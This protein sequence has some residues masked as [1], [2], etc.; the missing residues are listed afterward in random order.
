MFRYCSC[1]LLPLYW[2]LSSGGLVGRSGQAAPVIS[3]L[4]FHPAHGERVPEPVEHEWIEIFNPGPA[5]D[6]SGWRLT[7]GVDLEFPEGTVVPAGGRLVVAAR[8]E[9]FRAAYIKFTGRLVGG[10]AGRLSNGGETVRLVD[11]EGSVIDEVTYADEGDWATRGRTAV[12]AYGRVGW[13]WFNAADGGG[14]SLEK[15]VE[16]LRGSFGRNWQPSPIDGGTPGRPNT[17]SVSEETT[18]ITDVAAAPAI[19]RPGQ[20]IVITAT[21][22]DV[23][24]GSLA[25]RWLLR[26]RVDGEE[27]FGS[28]DMIET[29]R[30]ALTAPNP[31]GQRVEV[32]ATLPGQANRA[33]IEFYLEVRGSNGRATWP[34]LA[35]VTVPGVDPPQFEPA[36]NALIQV[37]DTYHS[38]TPWSPGAQPI[39]RLVL[40]AAELAY[41]RDLQTRPSRA[42]S[43]ATMNATFIS[44][45]GAGV[46]VRWLCGVR[47]RGYSSRN[48]PPNN[49]HLSFPGDARWEE[50]GSVQFNCR[51][52][53][54][55]VLGTAAYALAG[56][57]VQEAAPVQVRLNGTN[58]AVPFSPGNEFDAA[59]TRGSYA[60]VET[61]GGDWA[62]RHY[63]DDSEG[64]LY[65]VDDHAPGNSS[66]TNDFRYPGS[67]DPDLYDDVY[68]KQTN[69]DLNDYSDLAT[70]F[71][72]L[73][74]TA[75]EEFYARIATHLNLDQWLTYFAIDALMGNMEGGFVNGRT[76]DFSMYRGTL[77]PRFV[78]IPHDMDTTFNYGAGGAGNPVTRGLFSYVTSGGGVA[79]LQR[80]FSDPDILR[81]Y[82]AKVL[83]LLDTVFTRP[84]FDPLIDQL[85]GGWVNPA[86]VLVARTYIDDRRSNVL[87]QIPRTYS[88]NSNL[89]TEVDGFAVTTTGTAVF[90]GTFDVSRTGSIRLNG[91]PATLYYRAGGENPAGSWRF[92]STNA[93]GFLGRGVTRV[94]AEFFD[95]AGGTGTLLHRAHLDVLNTAGGAMTPV[96]SSGVPMAS[97]IHV[98]AP[99]TYM[100]GHPILVKVERRDALGGIDRS[101]W[102]ESVT[103]TGNNGIELTA[104][105]GGPATV[106]LLNGRGSL[107][108]IVGGGTAQVRTLIEPGGTRQSPNASAALWKYLDSGGAPTATWRTSRSF[109]DSAWKPVD[110][111]GAPGHFGA[112]DDD[113]RTAVAN[114]P[115]SAS[116][117]DPRFTWYFRHR[118]EVV[119]PEALARASLRVLYD[120][121]V[122]VYVN[123]AEIVRSNLPADAAHTTPAIDIRSGTA[124]NSFETFDLPVASLVAGE[125]LIAVELHNARTGS[126]T[127]SLDLGFDLELRATERVVDP[128]DFTLTATAG[129]V[130]ASQAVVSLGATPTV[131]EVS[132]VL[133]GDTSWS[134]VVRVT[135]DV[136]VPPGRT[137]TVQPGTHVLL[138]G[139]TAAGDTNGSDLVVQGALR[140]DGTAAAPISLTAASPD[141]RWGEIVLAGGGVST[142]SH[143]LISRGGHSPGRGHTGRGPMLRLAEASATLDDCVLSDAPGKAIFTEGIG[144]LVVRRSHLARCVTGPELGNGMSLL[145]EDSHFTHFLPEY[146]ESDAPGPDD[147]DCLYVHNASGRPVVVRRSVLGRCGDDVIDGLGGPVTIEDCLIRD[148]WDKGVSLLNNDLTMTRT[149]VIGCDKAV[150]AKSSTATTRS[151]TTTQCTLVS[152]NHDT[153]R[154]PWGYP[155]DPTNPDD[156]TPSTGMYTQNKAAQSHTGATIAMQARNCVIVA[157]EPIRVDTPY[158]LGGTAVAYS[159]TRNPAQPL[160]APWPGPGNLSADPE[161]VAAAGASRDFRLRPASPAVNAGDPASPA[162]PDGS[163][164]DMGALPLGGRSIEPPAEIVWK[165]AQSPLHVQD[166]IVIP[167][168]KSLTI[169]PGVC[170]IFDQNRRLTVHGVLRAL[171]TPHARI[172]FS[173]VPGAVAVGDADPIVPGIQIGPPKWGGVRIVDSMAE[174]NRVGHATFIN[175]QG[176]ASTGSEN[177]GSVGIIRSWALCEHLDFGGTKLRWLYGRNSKLTVQQCRFP[178]RF[179][180]DEDPRDF[181]LENAAEH[182]K[183]EFP[184]SDPEVQDNPI[185]IDGFP[186]GGWLRIYDNDFFGTKGLNDALAAESGRWGGGTFVLDCQFNRFHGPVGDEHIELSGDAYIAS[187]FFQRAT[188]DEWTTDTGH[189]AAVFS[190]SRGNGTTIMM[191]RNVITGV[192]H[193]LNL[194][195]GAAAFFEHNTAVRL[196]PDYDH[197][198]GPLPGTV[199]PIATSVVNLFVPE[200]GPAPIPGHGAYFGFN[201]A[202]DIPRF[203]G[204]ADRSATGLGAVTSQLQ[205]EYN[206]LDRLADPSIGPNHP[207]GFFDPRWG[208]N[209]Q[210]APGFIDEA[211][212]DFRLAVGSDARGTAPGGLDFGATVAEWAYV[213]GGPPALTAQTSASFAIGGPGLVAFRWSLDGGAWSA[214]VP[215]GSGGLYPRNGTSVRQGVLTLEALPAGNHAL[216]VLGQD[217]A[218]NWQPESAPTTRDWMVDP[219]LRLVLI[220]EIV[221]DGGDEPDWIELHNAGA[222]TVDLSGWALGESTDTPAYSFPS[223]TKL[224]AGAYL[225]I[226]SPLSGIASDNDGDAVLLWEGALLRDRVAFGAQ[227]AGF[228]L[229]R[230]GADMTWGLG[231]PTPG[232]ANQPALLGSP[233]ALRLSEWLAAHDVGYSDD[234]IELHNPGPLPVAMHGLILTDNR[235]GRPR[236]HIVAPLSFIAPTSHVAFWADGE[237]DGA[238]NHISFR[239]NALQ[240]RL[241]LLDANGTVIDEKILYGQTNDFSQSTDPTGRVVFHE[242]PTRGF[243]M[244]DS[245]PLYRN[246]VVVLRQLRLTEL[247]FNARGGNDFDWLELTNVGLVA[248]DL[249]GLRFVE[250]IDFVLPALVLNPGQSVVVVANTAAFQSRYGST[251]VVAGVY[252]G[253]LDNAGETLALRLAPPFDANALRFRYEDDWYPDTDGAGRA[254]DLAA[255]DIPVSQLDQASAWMA[256]EAI[257]GTPGIAGQLPPGHYQAWKAFYDVAEGDDD[258]D[259]MP[260]LLEFALGLNPRVCAAMPGSPALP[261][262][263]LN[264]NGR[265]ELRVR[266]PAN[267]TLPQGHGRPEV[268]YQ[269]QAGNGLEDWTTIASKAPNS[270]WTGSAV[271]TLASPSEG[272][273]EVRVVDSIGPPATARRYLRLRV[274]WAP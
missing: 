186:I 52:P 69:Q 247:M 33:V 249:T 160:T 37:D 161:F 50:L 196:N 148:G 250:G 274:S 100:P 23:V 25:P 163:R 227:P 89:T 113:E 203:V 240:D 207:G 206:L 79:G 138:A 106:M 86:T 74:N 6:L 139:T 49:Y 78:L 229:A 94:T 48:G 153:T 211:A 38:A 180:P 20:P 154:G 132:G 5:V 126:D 269:V 205:F 55:Q 42:E 27:A 125:N 71:D 233:A 189:S 254:L 39:H 118:F 219:T 259:G 95:G 152:D 188:K 169:E 158:P 187:N 238:A 63:P 120:D 228:S 218:G 147:E 222:Q 236:A 51:Y 47:N 110:A 31:S 199:Q 10:W 142:F 102:E 197:V 104:V 46:S 166:D 137:L 235:P 91:Q 45:D 60:R 232:E 263:S 35:R 242:L 64:N 7:R 239:L 164:A 220:N 29:R 80:F 268:L 16:S 14:A 103:L 119:D 273:V 130:T 231:V 253:R 272:R 135:G 98:E 225:R 213:V 256:S 76:D 11:R 66:V 26:W 15:N 44:H 82:Y 255:A 223:G 72:A 97:S 107:L 234:W 195:N 201:L 260:S 115:T 8:E 19:P 96:H 67:A 241:A 124:E 179:G 117:N 248:L 252:G 217:F 18:F 221:A 157:Q 198:S 146:R 123:G 193:A 194:A 112:G 226:P 246:A 210:G 34:A 168:G 22:H 57:P 122:V 92:N 209:L 59:I 165:A 192:D 200:D 4:M 83:E 171:G 62:D 121:G 2:L 73:N 173:H 151:I 214:P 68:F 87:G 270:Q 237:T 30:E 185:F 93:P 182:V 191:A 56:L 108:V 167:R 65:R 261:I 267:D 1:V 208:I 150:V 24:T 61:L 17:A 175:A 190:G 111:M 156:D 40:T 81:A 12:D 271:V 21:I 99:A 159:L 177:F 184:A 88:L 32:A 58:Y 264:P 9:V 70:L 243:A 257:D 114:V 101:V 262:A 53:Y 133:P 170:V 224:T 143:S 90:S 251:P 202:S 129:A 141:T 131:T 3:E 116:E 172:T 134:G 245:D 183:I 178:D 155:I 216:R 212:G 140:L 41:L 85:I 266:L 54:S 265:L 136:T 144:S 181:G 36:A 230:L 105:D 258:A 128:G 149:L 174:E 145:V 28:L 127:V 204:G 43:A 176:T 162:D 215:I 77:D 84:R 13:D 244:D 75:A 109:N